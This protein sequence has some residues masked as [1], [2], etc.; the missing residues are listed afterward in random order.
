MGTT[1]LHLTAANNAVITQKFWILNE[2]QQAFAQCLELWQHRVPHTWL[3]NICPGGYNHLACNNHQHWGVAHIGVLIAL[4]VC[5]TSQCQWFTSCWSPMATKSSGSQ[6]MWTSFSQMSHHLRLL[7]TLH[8]WM[9]LYAFPQHN[10]Y[11]WYKQSKGLYGSDTILQQW[12]LSLCHCIVV[13][14]FDVIIVVSYIR[15][16]SHGIW[17]AFVI[18]TINDA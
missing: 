15:Y 18:N 16:G 8:Q 12:I 9:P 5:E 4:W 6:R 13:E 10:L 17:N 1:G 3:L 11:I 14:I 2:K 7:R